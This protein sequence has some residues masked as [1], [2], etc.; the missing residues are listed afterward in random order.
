MGADSGAGHYDRAGLLA[1]RALAIDPD[2]DQLELALLRMYRS[3]GS[4]AAAAEQYSHYAAAGQ[5]DDSDP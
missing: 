2:A 1:R 3:A 4:H 5:E